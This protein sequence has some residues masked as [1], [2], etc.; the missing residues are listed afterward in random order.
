[1]EYFYF[2]LTAVAEEEAE[3]EKELLRKAEN[4]FRLAKVWIYLKESLV[5]ASSALE[6]EL[7]LIIVNRGRASLDDLLMLEKMVRELAKIHP[8]S[9]GY[10]KT[11]ITI[12]SHLT[13]YKLNIQNKE[14]KLVH[15]CSLLIRDEE[16]A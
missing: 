4:N 6:I 14:E 7:K 10:G 13:I 3:I 12:I 11:L 1:M 8:A 16:E 2:E 15:L 5:L 9:T